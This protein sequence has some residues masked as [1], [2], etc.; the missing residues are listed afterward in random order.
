MKYAK[1]NTLSYLH[2]LDYRDTPCMKITF[3]NSEHT[4]RV[5]DHRHKLLRFIFLYKLVKN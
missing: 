2:C 1:M 4:Y 3:K 5:K